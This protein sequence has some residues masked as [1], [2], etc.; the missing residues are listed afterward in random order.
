MT[1]GY[2]PPLEDSSLDRWICGF[3]SLSLAQG[4]R[5]EI[6][7]SAF[8]GV[9]LNAEVVR[10]DRSQSEFTTPI[11]NYIATAVSAQRIENGRIALHRYADLLK[12]IESRIGVEK[13][14]IVAIWGMESA[15]G[16]FRG[17]FPTIE[18]LAT[19]AHDGRR[20]EFFQR[21]LLA[22]L[23][24]LQAGDTSP[25]RMNGSWAGAMGHTQFMPETFIDYAL[26]FD[27]DGHR[28]VWGEDPA[29]AL[30]STASYLAVHGWVTGQPWGMEVILPQ[31]FDY[32][33]ASRQMELSTFDWLRM[34]IKTASGL[35]L[36]D[37]DEA[38]I[39][40]PA[41]HRGAAFMIFNNFNVL[42][43]YNAADSYVIGVGHLASRLSGGAPI[44]A[45]WPDGDRALSVAEVRDLQRL[46]LHRGFDPN[47]LDGIVGPGTT[48][49][50]Q[51]YQSSVGLVADGFASLEVLESLR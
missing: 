13:E 33:S 34:G 22:A 9:G 16:E 17:E 51:A 38:A 41:G 30:A 40:L 47:G 26:D 42:R 35:P 24:I 5:S 12:R 14:V 11:R 37:H 3:R 7:E 49:A 45:H 27:G 4:I 1:E 18:V 15:Y 43:R 32:S 10:K 28:N 19:L 48:A 21:Q 8:R 23:R 46:L 31:G 50:V 39:L 20:S 44:Q 29:D 25:D 6:F 36:P 2:E